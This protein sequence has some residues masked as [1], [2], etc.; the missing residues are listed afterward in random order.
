M[1]T[2]EAYRRLTDLF[3]VGEVLQ[4]AETGP[5]VFVHKL[6]DFE[7]GEARKDASVARSR[8]MLALRKEDSDDL[9]AL[10]DGVRRMDKTTIVEGILK[11]LYTKHVATA[12]GTIHADPAWHERLDV[13]D[14]TDRNAVPENER[15]VIDDINDAYFDEL[16]RRITRMDEDERDRLTRLSDEDLHQE[17]EE[18]FIESRAAAVF[19]RELRFAEIVFGVRMCDALEVT[20]AEDAEAGKWDHGKC[21]HER[22]HIDYEDTVEG[23]DGE[24][25]K[26]VVRA[27]DQVRVLPDPLLDAYSRAFDRLNVPARTAKGSARQ[28]SS[29]E[30]S[31]PPSEEEASVPSTPGATTPVPAGTSA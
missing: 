16:T 28:S 23:P 20:T 5:A 27:I 13:L 18:A 14:R 30:L 15:A 7:M 31:R 6:N 24:K 10:R 9:V 3:T 4:P 12:S 8:V 21:S 11:S 17:Y 26:V 29:S 2:R 25:H 22:L 19:L 1:A